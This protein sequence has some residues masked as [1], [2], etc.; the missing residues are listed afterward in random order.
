MFRE[1]FLPE[2]RGKDNSSGL[3]RRQCSFLILPITIMSELQTASG[4]EEFSTSQ[5]VRC[6]RHAGQRP[7]TPS[8]FLL[9]HMKIIALVNFRDG[10]HLASVVQ[11][12]PM[13]RNETQ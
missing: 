8:Q 11:P 5:W 13:G 1:A 2:T 6:R 4:D 3:L 10:A 12:F 7:Q 9:K